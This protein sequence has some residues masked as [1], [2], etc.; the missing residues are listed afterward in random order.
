MIWC[1]YLW[2]VGGVIVDLVCLWMKTPIP[3][4]I[5]AQVCQVASDMR[6]NKKW[7]TNQIQYGTFVWN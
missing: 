5:P 1:Q 6:L 7:P 4:P 2:N 3:L